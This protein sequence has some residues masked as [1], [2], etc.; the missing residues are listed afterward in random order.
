MCSSDYCRNGRGFVDGAAGN[1]ANAGNHPG[2]IRLG[3]ALQP[4]LNS[5][6]RQ[7]LIDLGFFADKTPDRMCAELQ[8]LA[9]KRTLTT[10]EASL[11]LSLVA[12][13]ERAVHPGRRPSSPSE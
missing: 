13:V 2:N 7:L 12:H 10:R 8:A 3:H 4:G 5:R 6:A 11:L 1:G 9:S